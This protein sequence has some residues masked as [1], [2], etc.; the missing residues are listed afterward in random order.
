MT[1][2]ANLTV[3]EPSLAKAVTIASG[4]DRHVTLSPTRIGP[5]LSRKSWY[6][7]LLLNPAL[8]YLD[9]LL[10]PIMLQKSLIA[11]SSTSSLKQLGG[12]NTKQT[13]VKTLL[14]QD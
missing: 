14:C 9:R 3:I 5:L 13:A 12:A 8:T 6:S 4:D 1:G 10:I 2:I 7:R 11:T